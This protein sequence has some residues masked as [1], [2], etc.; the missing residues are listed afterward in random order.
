MFFT[1]FSRLVIGMVKARRQLHTA[2]ANRKAPQ[3][4]FLNRVLEVLI[5]DEPVALAVLALPNIWVEFGLPETASCPKP[6]VACS[7]KD[8]QKTY[9]SLVC[10]NF[11]SNASEIFKQVDELL[12]DEEEEEEEATSTQKT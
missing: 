8:E 3:R 6:E 11:S 5:V 2:L 9:P 1:N 10:L 12:R 4:A 7:R